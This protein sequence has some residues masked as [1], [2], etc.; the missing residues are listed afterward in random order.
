MDPIPVFFDNV[1]R[2]A[3]VIKPKKPFIDW[4]NSIEKEMDIS[5]F[6]SDTDVYLLPDFDDLD[7]MK[8]SIKKNFDLFF[9]DFSILTNQKNTMTQNF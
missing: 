7:Q 5:D 8:S 3:L 9:C 2:S 1:N 6:L 4:L